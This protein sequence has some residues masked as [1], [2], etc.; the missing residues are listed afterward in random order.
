VNYKLRNSVPYFM[1]E[2]LSDPLPPTEFRVGEEVLLQY[3]TEQIFAAKLGHV[4][5]LIVGFTDI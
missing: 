1:G 2:G 5:L 4:H 3:Q